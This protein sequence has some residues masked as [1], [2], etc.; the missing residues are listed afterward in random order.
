MDFNWFTAI[1]EGLSN[2]FDA[3]GTFFGGASD[4]WFFAKY[5][6]DFIG[7]IADFVTRVAALFG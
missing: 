3:V 6:V 7:W 4:A 2:G 5:W 1:I